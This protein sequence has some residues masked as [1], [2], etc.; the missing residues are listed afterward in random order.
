ML[1]AKSQW[2][3]AISTSLWPYAIRLAMDTINNLPTVNDHEHKTPMESFSN[4]SVAPRYQDFHHFGCPVY[5]LK[6][7][8]QSQQS[9]GKWNSRV[10]LG[11]YLGMSPKHSRS[12][13]LVLNPRTGLVSPQSLLGDKSIPILL[14]QSCIICLTVPSKRQLNMMSYLRIMMNILRNLGSYLLMGAL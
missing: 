12:V 4:S 8:L 6:A 14:V 5:V 3:A 11:I 7:P 2:P 1:H 13:A 10:R 9:V